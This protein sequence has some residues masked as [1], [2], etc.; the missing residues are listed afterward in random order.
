YVKALGVGLGW[1]LLLAAMAGLG[2]SVVRRDRALLVL[3]SLPV[4]LFVVLG[5]QQLFFA[6]FLLPAVPALA[7]EAAVALDALV[8]VRPVL[9]LG[10]ALLVA[11]PALV[12][13]VRLDVMLTRV[14]TRRL[15]RDWVEANLP[16]D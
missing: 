2:L 16:E 15:A 1:P 12:D 4:V 13:S 9:G 11:M 8:T 7:V 5:A 3:G 10:L 14:D 6:R